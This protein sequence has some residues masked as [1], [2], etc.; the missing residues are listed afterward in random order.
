MEKKN[1]LLTFLDKIQL[2]W[3]CIVFWSACLELYW[4]ESNQF[5]DVDLVCDNSF[6]TELYLFLKVKQKGESDDYFDSLKNIQ[7]QEINKKWF[8]K[9]QRIWFELL[10]LEFECFLELDKDKWIFSPYFENMDEC[11]NN[12]KWNFYLLKPEY[13]KQSYLKIAKYELIS[14]KEDISILPKIEQRVERIGK[15]WI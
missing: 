4:I 2:D 6:F 5:H 3:K 7:L 11:T 13:L 15:L 1:I 8:G 14:L 12:Y 10:W 9:S